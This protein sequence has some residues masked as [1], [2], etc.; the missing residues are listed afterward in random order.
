MRDG[1]GGVR[2]RAPARGIAPRHEEDDED[3]AK[4]ER[5]HPPESVPRAPEIGSDRAYVPRSLAPYFLLRNLLKRPLFEARSFSSR[6]AIIRSP[7]EA[8]MLLGSHSRHFCHHLR[9][10][11]GCVRKN[12]IWP[13]YW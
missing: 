8:S 9:A 11:F 7:L 6:L 5:L 13:K 12:A 4:A 3:R 10:S 1:G 2:E